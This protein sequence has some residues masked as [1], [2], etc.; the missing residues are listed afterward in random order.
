M[1]GRGERLLRAPNEEG[2][3]IIFSPTA[4]DAGR[5]WGRVGRYAP[6]PRWPYAGSAWHGDGARL[7]RA[8]AEALAA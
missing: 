8:L 6:Q 5:C 1:R 7:L 2:L 4:K 3:P